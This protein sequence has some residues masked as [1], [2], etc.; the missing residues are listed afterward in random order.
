VCGVGSGG[1]IGFPSLCRG[2][3]GHVQGFQPKWSVCVWRGG[4][5]E[6]DRE[7]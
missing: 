2:C 3:S 4:N 1:Q 5:E 7:Y 6:S